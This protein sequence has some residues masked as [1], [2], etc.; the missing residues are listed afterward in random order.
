M[1]NIPELKIGNTTYDLHDKR[2]DN[3]KSTTRKEFT[4]YIADIPFYGFGWEQGSINGLKDHGENLD[5]PG[6]DNIVRTQEYLPVAGKSYRFE[7]NDLNGCSIMMF[8]YNSAKQFIFPA[9]DITS[10]R[11]IFPPEG[12][13]YI[14]LRIQKSNETVTV[15]DAESYD[16]RIYKDDGKITTAL[17]C[18]SKMLS[19]GN[20]I[21]TGSVWTNGSFDHLC[22]YANA[23][24]ARI[25][26]A[27]NLPSRNVHH[28]LKSSTGLIYDAGEGSFLDTILSTDITGYDYLLVQLFLSD[29]YSATGI[30]TENATANDGTIAGAVV[31]LLNYIQTNNVKCTLILIGMPPTGIDGSDAG[32]SI[33]H[34]PYGLSGETIAECDRVMRRLAK[35]HQFIFADWED[36]PVSYRWKSYSDNNNV[37]LNNEDAYRDVGEYLG[38]KVFEGWKDIKNSQ[39]QYAHASGQA[40]ALTDTAEAPITEFSV[41]SLQ[42]DEQLI[43][44]KK[45]LYYCQYPEMGITSEQ[46]SAGVTFGYS[47][48]HIRIYAANPT[49]AV[50]VS[51]PSSNPSYTSNTWLTIVNNIAYY[52][53]YKFKFTE[54]T[55]VFVSCKC[56]EF[57]DYRF[58]VGMT[59]SDG[60]STWRDTGFGVQLT[61][62]AGIEYGVRIYVDEGF[63]GDVNIYPQIEIG[64]TRTPYEPFDG[65]RV[66]LTNDVGK[67]N[68]FIFGPGY[69]VRKTDSDGHVDGRFN[70]KTNSITIIADGKQT[71]DTL[72]YDATNDS[73][74]NDILFFYLSKQIYV[75]SNMP[76]YFGGIP[77]RLID[78][79]Y[80]Q[81]SDGTNIQTGTHVLFNAES[82]KEY[83]YRIVVKSGV[84]VDDEIYPVIATGHEAIKAYGTFAGK[85][86]IVAQ[87]G[88]VLALTYQTA[89]DEN[90]SLIAYETA[91]KL[92]TL[93]SGKIYK[94]PSPFNAKKPVISF[95]DD[96]TSSIALVQQYHDIFS[97]KGV[98]GGYAVMTKNLDEQPGLAA[99]LLE[100]EQE[101]FAC[102][103]H[104]YYQAGD[105]TRYFEHRNPAYD[106]SLIKENFMRGLRDMAEYGFSN[107]KYWVTP[108][109]VNDDF[110]QSLA[111][112]HGMQCLINMSMT[113]PENGGYLTPANCNRYNI[114]RV[115][116]G[117]DIMTNARIQRIMDE[118]ISDNGW[119]IIM[120]HAN[121]WGTAG[122]TNVDTRL[123]QVID[124]ALNHGMEIRSFP[125]VF[126]DWRAVFYMNELLRL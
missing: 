48:D 13:A 6:Y 107:Y 83:A 73:K 118:C 112:R 63:V 81:V 43:I 65:A 66:N 44:T 10:W 7:H 95:I 106:E 17:A 50:A 45:N 61:A 67:K 26:A 99:K 78:K 123:G 105:A 119:M 15:A 90:M 75:N 111:K 30:G 19:F 46:K 33:F 58:P 102:L 47:P 89:T 36:S 16:I 97:A 35:K 1:P 85:T 88:S 114:Q 82:N 109:G 24:Y 68:I 25:A 113:D 110:I 57:M 49:T 18:Q 38:R 91:K 101:G 117:P 108:Y 8:K 20:S 9:E 5:G 51:T 42:N 56:S 74:V 39:S 14:R 22:D 72:L 77:E 125:D 4:E 96:D 28:T 27:L 104:C 70:R 12:V 69:G 121:T 84:I 103:Y 87:R 115:T 55:P 41:S 3:L 116:F 11:G 100:Y 124:Y 76:I 79:I 31:K 53:D 122:N 126:E 62:L 86:S 71:S 94:L 92:D 40:L 59:I 34:I 2:V 120:T 52:C 80:L 93:T 54:D 64:R 23:P 29:F 60:T 32:D 98:V 37:H 21:L